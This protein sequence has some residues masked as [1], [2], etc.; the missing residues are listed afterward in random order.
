MRIVSSL[1]F[2]VMISLTKNASQRDNIVKARRRSTYVSF[3]KPDKLTKAK[4]L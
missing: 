3:A 2:G 4:I 1:H